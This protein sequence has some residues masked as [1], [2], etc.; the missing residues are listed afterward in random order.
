VTSA[1]A[2]IEDSKMEENSAM[3]TLSASEDPSWKDDVKE[4]LR[5]MAKMK[6]ATT[7]VL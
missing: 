3:G 6:K 2:S 1:Q 4:V 5:L 7:L